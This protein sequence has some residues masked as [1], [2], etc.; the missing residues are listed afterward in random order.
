MLDYLVI[1]LLG[2]GCLILAVGGGGKI[3]FVKDP[4]ENSPLHA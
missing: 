4:G 2:R 3:C 1:I